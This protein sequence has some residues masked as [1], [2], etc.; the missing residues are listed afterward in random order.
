MKHCGRFRLPT[1]FTFNAWALPGTESLCWC[2]PVRVSVLTGVCEL[3]TVSLEKD[4]SRSL[5]GLARN[6]TKSFPLGSFQKRKKKVLLGCSTSFS[7]LLWDIALPP[8]F[9]RSPENRASLALQGCGVGQRIVWGMAVD[10]L[11]S[12]VDVLQLPPARLHREWIRSAPNGV[13]EHYKQ[14]EQTIHGG[15]HL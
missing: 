8:C 13:H 9:R 3:F 1:V 11:R 2:T 10:D 6:K 15:T 4:D 12:L 14:P 7:K 5:Q